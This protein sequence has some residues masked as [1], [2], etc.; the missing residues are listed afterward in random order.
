MRRIDNR[1]A[2][3]AAVIAVLVLLIFIGG[4]AAVGYTSSPERPMYA[5]PEG[6]T[7]LKWA[8]AKGSW[9]IFS[10]NPQTSQLLIGSI[11]KIDMVVTA[12]EPGRSISF[13]SAFLGIGEIKGEAWIA[14]SVTGPTGTVVG[15]WESEHK[16]DVNFD[17]LPGNVGADFTSGSACLFEAGQWVFQFALHFD[18]TGGARTLVTEQ[19]VV[20]V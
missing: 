13:T 5:P 15:N 8:Q 12:K 16:K 11:D 19:R 6:K 17:L 20:V 14:T 4:L 18:G 2:L 3:G 10:P 7:C 9:N 1:G